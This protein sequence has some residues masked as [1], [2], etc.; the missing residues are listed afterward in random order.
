MAEIDDSF[1]AEV[2]I[3]TGTDA[4]GDPTV[5]VSGEIDMSNAGSLGDAVSAIIATQPGRVTF[6]LTDLRFMDSAGI[7]VL[8]GAAAKTRVIV[9]NPSAIVRRVI[10]ATGLST[11]LNMETN[12]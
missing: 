11:V 2:V 4:A 3:A 12:P 9:R 1:D 7:A 10:E 5:A 6:D 8:V